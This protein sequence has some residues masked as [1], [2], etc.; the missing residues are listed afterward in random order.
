MAVLARRGGDFGLTAVL[1]YLQ[2]LAAEGPLPVRFVAATH[3]RSS[4]SAL[5]TRDDLA[6]L[7]DL[8]GRRLGG[9]ARGDGLGWMAGELLAGLDAR[10]AGRPEL[11]VMSYGEAL[12]ALGRGEIDAVANLEELLPLTRRRVGV[13]LR[14]L[15]LGAE[16][17]MSGLLAGDWVPG[18]VVARMRAAVRTAFKRQRD[19]PDRG[20]GE[21]LRRYPQVHAQDA[22]DS[23]SQLVP[24]VFGDEG[25][26]TMHAHRWS[27]TLEFLAKVHELSRPDAASVWRGAELATSS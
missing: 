10:G 14:A 20:L 2:A 15:P 17:Y 21:L 18:D 22:V 8:A 19:Q 9:P 5:V 7:P 23:W 3:Q 1:Y 6:A 16:T 11:V 25:P 12:A 13:P 26:T 24:Y 27:A 4:V